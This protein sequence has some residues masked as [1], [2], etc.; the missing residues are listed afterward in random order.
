VGA[1]WI[2]GKQ[3]LVPRR[4]VPLDT[5]LAGE[6]VALLGLGVVA[7]L[8]LATN[9]FALILLLPALH[10][11]IWLPQVRL[12]RAPARGLVFAAG[13]T[14]LLFVLLDFGMRF[15]LGLDAPWYL[16]RLAAVGYVGPTTVGIVLAAGACTAQL[17]AAAAG[18]YAPYPAR[19]E[20]PPRGPLREIVRAVVLANR[21]RRRE[22][23]R[24]RAVL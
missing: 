1:G 11:G 14:G 12:G 24:R 23:Q 19:G 18:R 7:L 22:Q 13:L 5:Q 6:T 20:R 2:V 4:P 9:P 15:G 17:G 16:V 10:T 8:V 3:R 21:G